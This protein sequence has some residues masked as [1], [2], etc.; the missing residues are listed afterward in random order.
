VLLFFINT[1]NTIILH[2][3]YKIK[4]L[5]EFSREDWVLTLLFIILVNDSIVN[6]NVNVVMKRIEQGLRE[7]INIKPI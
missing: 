7:K 5:C 6:E 1:Y 2:F 3:G 4:I